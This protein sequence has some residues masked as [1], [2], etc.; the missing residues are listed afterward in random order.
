MNTTT[1]DEVVEIKQLIK[2]QKDQGKSAKDAALHV[3]TAH[4]ESS[5]MPPA[6]RAASMPQGA[7][8][9]PS[10]FTNI[11]TALVAK[12]LADVYELTPLEMARIMKSVFEDSAGDIALGL[13][14]GYP[15]LSAF[16][17]GKILLDT[18]VYPNLTS[19][20][21]KTALIYGGFS[22]NDS[23]GAV[24]RLFSTKKQV[25][26]DPRVAWQDTGVTVDANERVTVTYKNGRWTASPYTGFVDGNGTP[27][28]IAKPG[29]ALPG[30]REAAL[31][32]KIG[33]NVFLIGNNGSVPTGITGKLLL[34]INDDLER[35]Y[36]TG[37]ADNTGSI[38]VE[39]EE[40]KN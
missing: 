28:Y 25:T 35:R 2:S 16:D 17:V 29:Y 22:E 3:K 36:G 1:Y 30:A 9:R 5:E 39:I 12:A 14:H 21:M 37:L 18:E 6:V 34:C 11:K 15:S 8:S 19:T 31:I 4:Q 24:A 10:F 27:R 38:T 26:V 23:S 20:E 33:N 32:G 7:L 13:K 40:K